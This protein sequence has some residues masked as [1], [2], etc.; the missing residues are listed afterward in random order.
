MKNIIEK[1]EEIGLTLKLGINEKY[2]K[3]TA[4]CTRKAKTISGYK[5]LFNYYYSTEERRDAALNEYLKK[6]LSIIEL[7]EKERQVKKTATANLKASDHYKV[8]EIIVNSWGWEQTNIEFYA[9][10]E[11]LPKS[12]KVQQVKSEMVE[13]SLMSHGMACDII[14]TDKTCGEPFILR[15]KADR[16]G[17]IWICNPQSYYYFH[18]WDGR[19]EYRSWY[20]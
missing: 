11:V 12:I 1:F 4:L 3:P 17:S 5:V 7:K 16:N 14:P 8:G 2:N 10:I 9:I 6:Q 13:G 19:P 18:K 20:A 15:L